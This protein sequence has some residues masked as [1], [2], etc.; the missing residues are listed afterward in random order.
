MNIKGDLALHC[1]NTVRIHNRHGSR[2]LTLCHLFKL[3]TIM[4]LTFLRADVD[5]NPNLIE[6]LSTVFNKCTWPKITGKIYKIYKNISLSV[7]HI[8]PKNSFIAV[9]CMDL[10]LFLIFYLSLYVCLSIH[11]SVRMYNLN[12]KNF[13]VHYRTSQQAISNQSKKS[14]Q[15]VSERNIPVKP[16][17][18]WGKWGLSGNMLFS[19]FLLKKKKKIV[20]TR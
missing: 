10:M 6:G 15:R 2:Q 3:Q 4:K 1:E 13:I 17:L 11:Q 7:L 5:S 19:L 14:C 16:F 8:S 12:C 20:G 9:F 18:Y